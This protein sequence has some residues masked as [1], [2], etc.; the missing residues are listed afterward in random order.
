MMTPDDIRRLAATFVL[1]TLDGEERAQARA[2][3]AEDPDVA[4]SV[5]LWEDR[6]A[7]LHVLS[8]AVRP[9][10]GLWDEVLAALPVPEP[11]PVLE[12]L[13]AEAVQGPADGAEAAEP[14]G[15]SAEGM[16]PEDTAPDA[17]LAPNADTPAREPE[18]QMPPPPFGRGRRIGRGKAAGCR[19]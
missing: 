19:L 16:R 3:L 18:A 2:L 1:G 9:P 5:R 8:P 7:P 13:F 4:A 12:D 11:E 10:E 15:S 17:P 6:L 14:Y